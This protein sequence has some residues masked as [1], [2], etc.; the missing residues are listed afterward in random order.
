LFRWVPDEDVSED[1]R[2][3]LLQASTQYLGG[4]PTASVTQTTSSCTAQQACFDV[5]V[6][7]LSDRRITLTRN[8]S[9]H[10]YL[11]GLQ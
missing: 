4:L 7:G 5:V 6:N 3:F 8:A 2:V 11:S 9:G 1:V 10:Y